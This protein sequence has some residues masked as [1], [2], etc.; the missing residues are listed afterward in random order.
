VSLP[1]ITCRVLEFATVLVE[2]LEKHVPA[3]ELPQLDGAPRGEQSP[4]PAR[5]DASER[6]VEFGRREESCRV[7]AL[8][9]SDVWV[10]R[11]ASWRAA[12][13]QDANRTVAPGACGASR[14][15]DPPEIPRDYM[16]ALKF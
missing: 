3:V 9:G 1:R 14:A 10:R 8:G 16:T 4:V 6:K 11:S 15:R 2:R 5:T 13:A 12:T 7:L